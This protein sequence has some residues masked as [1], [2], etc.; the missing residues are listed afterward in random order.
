MA[1]TQTAMISPA[2][3]DPATPFPGKTQTETVGGGG[4]DPRKPSH[5]IP[6]KAHEAEGTSCLIS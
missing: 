2:L 6:G 3:P 5:G 4:D 1:E